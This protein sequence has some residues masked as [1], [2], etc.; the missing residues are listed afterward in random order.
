MSIVSS[1]YV[2]ASPLPDGSRAVT[3]THTDST[4]QQHVF[5]WVGTANATTALAAHAAELEQQ[6][7]DAEADAL[8]GGA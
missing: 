6:L 2:E 1:S 4:G 5:S 7:A 3:E 8:L